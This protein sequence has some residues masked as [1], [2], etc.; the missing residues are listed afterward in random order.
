MN[1][2]NKIREELNIPYDC[3]YL[4]GIRITY[5]KENKFF[6]LNRVEVYIYSYDTEDKYSIIMKDTSRYT[7]QRD[8][9]K[10]SEGARK[11]IKS[12]IS[13][14][15]YSQEIKDIILSFIDDF[16]ED[17]ESSNKIDKKDDLVVEYSED[18]EFSDKILLA[19]EFD[20]FCDENIYRM[21]TLYDCMRIKE[22]DRGEIQ[23]K[24]RED[25]ERYFERWI[26]NFTDLVGSWA[27]YYAP[28]STSTVD[29]T[30]MEELFKII[31]E[32]EEEE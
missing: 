6:Y 20:N 3:N 8:F 10:S 19:S 29:Y 17:K 12:I 31:E 14:E 13:T 25:F 2:L 28:C 27:T 11:E 30:S 9:N 32:E 24:I 5:G 16:Y 4:K 18:G 7:L 15:L 26:R 22:G 1:V 21:I 23:F